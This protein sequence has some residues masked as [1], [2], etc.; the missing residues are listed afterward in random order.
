MILSWQDR[1]ADEGGFQIERSQDA[2]LFVPVAT[3]GRNVTSYLDRGL[4]SASYYFYRVQAVNSVGES[5]LSN[6]AAD[7][8]HPQSQLVREGDTVSF[9]AGVEGAP[10]VRYQW[11]FMGSDL[12]GETN[13]TL[14]LVAV[15][16]A[17]QGEYTVAITDS[18][19]SKVSNPATL[20]VVSPPRIVAHPQDAIRGVGMSV[21]LTVAVEGT[22][23]FTYYW[24]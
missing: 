11:Q 21:Q 18:T 5:G 23:P 24:R 2:L 8:T 10:A 6:L 9:H 3:V 19:G 14:T 15:D 20:A 4:D 16:A 12:A 1:S 17:D 13:E 7:Q 22:P